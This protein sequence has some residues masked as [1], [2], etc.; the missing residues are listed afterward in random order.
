MA[1]ITG[2]VDLDWTPDLTAIMVG[3]GVDKTRAVI[4]LL[5]QALALLRG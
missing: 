3:G 2:N 4:A 1:G 5:E